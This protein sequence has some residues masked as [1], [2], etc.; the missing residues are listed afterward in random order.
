M[1]HRM[2]LVAVLVLSFAAGVWYASP[3]DPQPAPRPRPTLS[4]IAR[5]AR[6]GLWC[7]SFTEP[8]PEPQPAYLAAKATYDEHGHRELNN[9]EGW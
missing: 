3:A 5:L 9:A 2:Q 4:L 7:A 8:A 1:S 6:L